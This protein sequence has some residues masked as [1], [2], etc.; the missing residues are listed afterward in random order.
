MNI[1]ELIDE[2]KMYLQTLSNNER[3]EDYA[4]EMGHAKMT[5]EDFILHIA[6]TS[7]PVIVELN[8]LIQKKKE[9][10]QEAEMHLK[11][12]KDVLKL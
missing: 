11:S 1:E 4:T 10:I 9:E 6:N 2:S 12:A 5:L 3:F 7:D 8:N